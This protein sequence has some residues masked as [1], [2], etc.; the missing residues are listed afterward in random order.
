[1]ENDPYEY[2]SHREHFVAYLGIVIVI[3]AILVVVVFIAVTIQQKI[4][5][6]PSIQC[7]MPGALWR[8]QMLQI[9]PFKQQF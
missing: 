6:L 7:T 8:Q 4:K 9:T 2:V 3:A 1:M 5:Q